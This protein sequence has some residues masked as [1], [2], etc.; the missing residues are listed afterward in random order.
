[1]T[2]PSTRSEHPKATGAPDYDEPAYWDAKFATGKDV[3]EWLNS[4][5]I[6]I[7]TTLSELARRPQPDAVPRA[8]HL[9]PGISKL[10][11]KLCEAFRERNWPG[12]CIVVSSLLWLTFGELL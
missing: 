4:G 8:L 1:M 3:G 10:G 11:T 7:D 12:S 2:P 6:L 9:G 5:E